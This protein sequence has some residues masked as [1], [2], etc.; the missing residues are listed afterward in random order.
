MESEAAKHR[1]Q[2]FIPTKTHHS[3]NST[4]HQ[5]SAE[6]LHT[7]TKPA[8]RLQT[9]TTKKRK[10]APTHNWIALRKERKERSKEKK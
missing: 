8:P 2:N 1:T 10:P 6:R 9:A 5:I 3:N 4:P 7:T